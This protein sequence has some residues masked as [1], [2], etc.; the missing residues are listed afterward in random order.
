MSS[1]VSTD[2]PSFEPVTT[3]SVDMTWALDSVAVFK[4]RLPMW[5]FWSMTKRTQALQAWIQSQD[6]PSAATMFQVQ[7]M[8]LHSSV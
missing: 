5:A 3:L 6:L 2:K 8:M 4:A 7:P 1:D